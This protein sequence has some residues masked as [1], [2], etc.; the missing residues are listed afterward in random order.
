[1]RQRWAWALILWL[2]LG[3]RLWGLDQHNIW[4]DEGLTAWAARLPVQGILDWTAHDVHPPLY[5]LITRGWWLVM[6]DGAWGLRFLPA[7]AGVLAVALGAGLA[8]ALAGLR[9]GLLAGLFLALSPFAVTWSQELRMYIWAALWAAATLWAALR[10]WQADARAPHDAIGDEKLR[11]NSFSRSIPWIAYVLCAAAG[12]WTLYLSAATLAVANLAFLWMWWRRNRDKGLLIRW[13]IAQAAVIGLFVPWLAYALPRMMSWSSA[14]PYQPGFFLRLYATVLATG[15]AADLE[16]WT[17]PTIAVMGILALAIPALTLQRKNTLRATGLVMLLLG[18]VLPAGLVFALTLPGRTF[19]V[20]RLAPRYFLPLAACFYILLGWGLTALAQR[21]RFLGLACAGIVAG[22]SLAGLAAL[23]TGRGQTDQYLSLAA[24]LGAHRRPADAVVLYTDADWPLFVAHYPG[25][26]DRV[27]GGMA[28]SPESVDHLLSPIWEKAE[29]VW[30]VVIPNAQQTDPSHLV[31]DWLGAR[32]AGTASWS[33][34]ETSLV[35][36][37]RTADRATHIHDLRPGY[38]VPDNP[39]AVVAEGELLAAS[40]PLD[41]YL[42]GDILHLALIWAQ[43]PREPAWLR[44][45]GPTTRELALPSPPAV[46]TGPTRQQL[47]WPLLPDL[48]AGRYRLAL[49]EAERVVELARFTLVG[50]QPLLAGA[51][52]GAMQSL[53][54][55]LGDAIRLVGYDLPQTTVRPGEAVSLTLYWEAL[56]PIPA[57]YKVFTHLVGE[58]WNATQGNFLW[59]QQDNEPLA[60]RLP[61]TLW[62]PGS[63]I[64]DPYRIVLDPA[65]PPGVY[66]LEVGMYGLVDGVRLPLFDANGKPLGDSVTLTKITVH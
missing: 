36:Y 23:Y 63:R 2:A 24:T 28:I 27:P 25:Q 4:W 14:E 40:L 7:V 46:T 55:R 66:T 48:P 43:P 5:F 50:R 47:D 17:W 57:R 12:L 51:M 15:A 31:S 35:L 44:L 38:P 32:A 26:W 42:T 34:G 45:S 21:R 1:M 10:V 19:Y 39:V 29:G 41:R 53:N 62:A 13:A 33:Y 60:D 9:A 3:L 30:L 11:S 64:A 20:P 18:L 61:T 49:A 22:V 6:G 58:T 54:L 16:V 8:R 56:A 65:A 52:A 59:G 37:A